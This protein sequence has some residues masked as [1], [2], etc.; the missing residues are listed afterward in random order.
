MT[1][2]VSLILVRRGLNRYMPTFTVISVWLAVVLAVLAFGSVRSGASLLFVAIVAGAGIFLGRNALIATIVACV[3]IQGVFTIAEL[4]GWI[5]AQEIRVGFTVWLTHTAAFVVTGV[6]VYYSRMQAWVAFV[7]QSREL[8]RRKR[9]EQERDRSQERFS[10]IFHSSPSAMVA[11]SVRSG[12]I[13][14]T[15]PAF[16]RCYGYDK[17]SVLGRTDAFLWANTV[18]RDQYLENMLIKRG[19]MQASVTALRSDGS[20]FIALV[21][22]EISSDPG[23]R[24]LITT[25]VDITQERRRQAQ[26]LSLASGLAAPCGTPLLQHLTRHMADTIGA[27]AISVNE[28]LSDKQLHTLSAWK[29]GQ[30]LENHPL[31]D[32]VA[33][34]DAVEC[35]E[36]CMQSLD[37]VEHRH[38][39]I[40]H[41]ETGFEVCIGQALRDENGAPMGLLTAAWRRPIELSIETRSLIAIFASR[42]TAE[43]MRLRSERALEQLNQTLEQRVIERT[44]EL[45]KLNAELDSF[46][47]SISHDLKSPLRAIDGFTQLLSERL[48]E[49][50]DIEEQQLMERVLG[51]T[52]RMATL[53]A[54]LLALTRVSQQPIH[55]ERL[56]LSLMA[57]VV[58]A[59]CL[60][61]QPRAHL[62]SRIEL[63]LFVHADAKLTQLLLKHLIEN[64]VKYTRDQAHPVIEVGRISAEAGAKH[65]APPIF[66]VR[67]NGVGFSMTHTDKLFKPFQRLHMPSAGFEGTGIGLATVRRIVERHGGTIEAEASVGAGAEFQFSLS[68][69]AHP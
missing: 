58:L 22:S 29:D 8:E 41:A 62:V 38:N 14:D 46:A 51:A 49:R 13:L 45:Q 18:E 69:E 31:L 65:T 53:M 64:A 5:A 43:L 25:V 27:D 59:Q 6:M 23:D 60:K 47:Y 34:Q 26:L 7:N 4:Q 50:L 17:Q 42:A 3:G 12:L 37:L 10:R 66:F 15:N 39:A 52:H 67:D 40:E 35:I 20:Q 11:Q 44:A 19:S 1:G 36:R 32:E 24:L 48:H 9:T 33:G 55:I 61:K 56:N 57:E 2:W 68:A 16:E 30:T 54:D 63:G 28:C 21:S